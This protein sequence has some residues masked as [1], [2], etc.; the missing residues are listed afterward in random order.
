MND[1]FGAID[2]VLARIAELEDQLEGAEQR[3]ALILEVIA[4]RDR[5]KAALTDVD[6]HL[7]NNN[8]A[9]AWSA[10]RA[11]LSDPSVKP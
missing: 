10:A 6:M 7:T 3:G 4:E 5:L 11:A 2:I 8:I 1:T 9:L